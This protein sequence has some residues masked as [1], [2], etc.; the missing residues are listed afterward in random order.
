MD[1][2]EA[3]RLLK[4][5]RQD[6]VVVMLTSYQDEYVTEALEA[7]ASGYVLKACTR[8]QLVQALTAAYQGQVPIDPSLTGRL[9]RKMAELERAHRESLLTPRQLEILKLVA[10]GTRYGEIAAR[11]FVSETTVNREMRNIFNRL[12]VHDAVHAVS[13]A[14]RKRLI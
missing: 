5:K 3:T 4:Q 13:E 6:M 7:G 12:G 1:G 2:I 10:A 11:L 8:Q 14:Y 9:V